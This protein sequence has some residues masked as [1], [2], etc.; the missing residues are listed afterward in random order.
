MDESIKNEITRKYALN[1][2]RVIQ[3]H[4]SLKCNLHC[5]HCYSSSDSTFKNY[6]NPS[7]LIF[8]LEYARTYGFDILSVSGGEP[9]LYP[10]L[11]E[12]LSGSHTIGNKNIAASN[13]MLFKSDNSQRILKKLD[14]IAISID[15]EPAF[16]DEI[17]SLNGAFEKMSEGVEIIKNSGIDFGFIHTITEQTWQKLFWL[18]EFAYSKGATLLQLHP[19]ELTGRALTDFNHLQPSQESL[20]K[21]FIIGNYL[22]EK[23]TNKMK[24]QLDFLHSKIIMHSPQTIS[25]FG[26]E[27]ELNKTNFS[28][29]IKCLV[30]NEDGNIYPMSYGFSNQFCLGNVS[31]I[32]KGNDI[33]EQ[34]IMKKG[35]D[36]YKLITNVFTKIQTEFPDDLIAWTEMIVKESHS[37]I[38]SP[39]LSDKK[40]TR[41][42]RLI[43]YDD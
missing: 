33:F 6:L 10:G 22:E 21:V 9:F 15:G 19:L 29:V 5:K 36:L 11:E 3:I 2:L 39:N 30:V 8:F 37:F 17:R 25:F 42:N 16:H 40:I 13:G 26:S 28:D 23:Y 12:L 35:K 18:A 24:V 1:N 43:N 20:H 27:F 7:D 32:K 14:L 38:S 34:F 4:P 31:S 41:V